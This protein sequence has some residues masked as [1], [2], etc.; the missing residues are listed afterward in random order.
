MRPDQPNLPEA[1]GHLLICV[2]IDL[3]IHTN[4]D[5]NQSDIP[6][7]PLEEARLHTKIAHIGM[8]DEI[9]IPRGRV[10]SPLEMTVDHHLVQRRV[11]TGT[12]LGET[13]LVNDQVDLP[14]PV[15]HF[16][17]GKKPYVWVLDL[18]PHYHL[19]DYRHSHR[20]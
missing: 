11:T 17:R 20:T 10:D 18:H 19:E 7:D 14:C 12:V 8:I 3:P 13:I 6:N 15:R 9:A 4:I 16:N 2:V 1:M 5:Q